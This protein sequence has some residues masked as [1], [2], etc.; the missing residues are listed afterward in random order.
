MR[1]G[2]GGGTS[3]EVIETQHKF[4]FYLGELIWWI[5]TIQRMKDKLCFILKKGGVEQKKMKKG[6]KEKW[7]RLRKTKKIK[8][9]EGKKGLEVEEYGASIMSWETRL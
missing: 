2:R 4:H 5:H 3:P 8:H 9:E 1:E 6:D 7:G